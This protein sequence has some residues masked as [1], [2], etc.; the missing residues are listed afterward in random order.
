ML[1]ESVGILARSPLLYAVSATGIPQIDR[2]TRALSGVRNHMNSV[3]R[4]MHW[5]AARSKGQRVGSNGSSSG[6]V[7]P[8]TICSASS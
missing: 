2:H 6:G 4:S 5:Y 7:M 1:R 3:R 8:V